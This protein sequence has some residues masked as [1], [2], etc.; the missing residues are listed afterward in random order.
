MK[1]I[2]TKLKDPINRDWILF[3]AMTFCFM[4]GFSSYTGIFQNFFNTNLH[5]QPQQLGILETFREIPG[6]LAAPI[7]ATL[8]FLHAP[9]LAGLTLLGSGIGI[10][11]TGH[12]TIFWQLVLVSISWSIP[13]HLWFTI[14]P[15]IV[16][17]LAQ[18]KEGGRHLGRNNA[19]GAFAVLSALTLSILLK[20]HVSYRFMFTL[21]G[22]MI[23]SAGVLGLLLSNKAGVATKPKLFLRKQYWLFYVL[24]FLEGSRRQTF[25]TFSTFVLIKVYHMPVEKM[26]LL[27]LANSAV[28]MSFAPIVGKIID[29]IGERRVLTFYYICG[30]LVFAAYGSV[31]SK[32]V[33]IGLFL[34][35]NLLMT[36]NM[37][38][39]TYITKI[40]APRELR[41]SLAMG[42]SVNHISAVTVPLIGGWLWATYNNYSIPFWVGSFLAIVSLYFVQ[43]LPRG[44]E[45]VR[46]E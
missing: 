11:A 18:G 30:A 25:A 36:H 20:P 27:L 13:M 31:G 35:D 19:I 22:V 12:V 26:L 32:E 7:A 2:I 15:A 16:M 40:A 24:N 6:L 9:V 33:L 39:T 3:S 1:K 5:G 34:L 45:A 8:A 23:S 46:C 37:G 4:F 28:T 43:R 42:V 41:P 17:N 14:S 29:R 10:W 21:A 44:L 38:I